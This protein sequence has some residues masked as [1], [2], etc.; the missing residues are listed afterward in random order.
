[1]AHKNE[2]KVEQGPLPGDV[3]HE[4]VS[5]AKLAHEDDSLRGGRSDGPILTAEPKRDADKT[6]NPVVSDAEVHDPPVRSAKAGESSV[7]SMATGAGQHQPPS[8]D[9]YTWDGRPR[10]LPGSDE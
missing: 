8:L 7:V 6:S 3:K 5:G 9:E 2:A 1:M 10:G 4:K